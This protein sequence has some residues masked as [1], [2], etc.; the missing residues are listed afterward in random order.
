[1]EFYEQAGT[2]ALGS[3]LRCLS[4]TVTADA[5]RIFA[6]Y[7]V[8][9]DPR[10]FP[11]FYLLAQRGPTPVTQIARAVGHS[12]ASV[13]QII[14]DMKARRLV[15]T[16][17]GKDDG[18]VT[19]VRLSAAGRR[20]MEPLEAQCKDVGKAVDELLAEAEE[21]LWKAMVETEQLLAH[22]SLFDRVRDVRKRRECETVQIVDYKARYRCD[23]ARLNR[24]W[25]EQYFR[26]EQADRQ[27]L[28]NPE[29]RVL[30]PGGFIVMALR[31]GRA[32]G[33]CAMLKRP[34][35]SYELAKMAVTPAEYGKGI[36]ELL[37]R[38]A[39]ARAR[40]RGAQ[41]VY[42]ESNSRLEP[43]I[44]LYRKLGFREFSGGPSPYARCDVQMELKL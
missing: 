27:M 25:I 7:N 16:G 9:L 6:W 40:Q 19:V 20:L 8:G 4:E 3:R 39:L 14:R 32:V 22:R 26:L 38:A 37:A 24:E 10:W 28:D 30:K 17:T 42:L 41:R 2:V 23:F 18:R 12:H 34:D 15:L 44:Y 11:V 36:G 31:E 5:A 29:G 33:T 35:D 1:M 43:A 21:N 13:S